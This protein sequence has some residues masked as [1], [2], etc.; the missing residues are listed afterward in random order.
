M[1]RG[2]AQLLSIIAGK[3][4]ASQKDLVEEIDVRP[5]SMTEALIKMEAAGLITRKQDENDQRVMRIF[6][7]EAGERTLLQ[8]N[9]AALD[10]AGI[11][12]NGLTPEEQ[13]QMLSLIEKVSAGLETMDR[14]GMFGERHRGFH[15]EHR[16]H[17]GGC[18]RDSNPF[19]LRNHNQD[20][21][22]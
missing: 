21:D 5:S 9:A 22:R 18:L 4:G 11:L 20:D 10:L 6:L 14:S 8:S 13:A 2:Q 15:R 1:H 17:H 19:G 3:N 7:T 16:R 12:F